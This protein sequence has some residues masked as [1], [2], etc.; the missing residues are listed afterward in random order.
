METKDY[1]LHHVGIIFNCMEKAELFIKITGAREDYR[2]YVDA[3]QA[4][5]VFLEANGGSSIELIIP[6][7]GKLSEFNNGKGGIHHIAY[8]VPDVEAVRKEYLKEGIALLEEKGV[9][10]AG[11][12][13]VNFLKPRDACGVLVEFVETI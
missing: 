13:L 11:N 1:R 12:I 5:C 4:W 6:D 3:Y 10:G 9:P 8:A 7:G 2:G